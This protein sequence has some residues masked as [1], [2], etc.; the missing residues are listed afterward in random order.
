MERGSKVSMAYTKDI[1]KGDWK[2]ID[3]TSFSVGAWEPTHD[4]ELWKQRKELHLFIQHTSQGDGEK[5]METNT[6]KIYVFETNL[7]VD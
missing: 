4:T 2:I 7:K 5:I 3:L 6:Q 1:E